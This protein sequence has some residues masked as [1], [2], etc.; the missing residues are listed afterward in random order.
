[1]S[2]S[3]TRPSRVPQA[4]VLPSGEYDG[5][6]E[7]DSSPSARRSLLATSARCTPVPHHA[8]YGPDPQARVLPSGENV[9]G[10]ASPP[11]GAM[12]WICLPV[13]TSHRRMASSL[14]APA[15]ARVLPSGE[16]V[17]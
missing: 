7:T 17:N 9:N 11:S 2:H 14:D 13:A 16:N 8:A 1:M 3:V 5:D 12:V 4:R 10:E 6:E 15:E